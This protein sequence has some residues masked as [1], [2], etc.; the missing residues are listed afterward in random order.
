[1]AERGQ[2]LY[3]LLYLFDRDRIL[4]CRHRSQLWHGIVHCGLAGKRHPDAPGIVQQ[5]WHMYAWHSWAMSRF[6]H[7]RLGNGLQVGDMQHEQR[8]RRW[9]LL[10]RLWRKLH[11]EEEHWSF[12]W[13]VRPVYLELLR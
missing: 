9:L 8:L 11:G 10:H 7:L 12:V 6:C 3:W 4:R 2:C 1:M 13:H 5:F